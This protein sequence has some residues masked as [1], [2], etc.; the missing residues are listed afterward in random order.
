MLQTD[1][2]VIG[3]GATAMAFVDTLLAETTE[4][5]I[6]IV[7]R[8]PKPGGH[9]NFAY[10]FVTLHQ[11]STFYGVSS[12]ELSDGLINES[13]M[14]KGLHSL[15]N[16]D[17]IQ[18]YYHAVMEETFLPSG[19]IQ[20]FP[21]C[22]YKGEHKFESL[23]TGEKYE[24]EVRK[25]VVDT[26]YY[27]AAV[28]ATHTPNFEIAEGVQFM[29]I[30]GLVDVKEDPEGYVVVGGGKTGIDACLYLLENGTDPDKISWI[31]P[32]DAWLTNRQYTQPGM[33]FFEG[34]MGSQA[35]QMEAMATAKSI[36][37]MYEKL[38]AAEVVIRI[39]QDIF[40]KMFHGAT[41]SKPEVKA[42]RK[43]R[44]IIRL[45]R[46]QRIET[47]QIIF[48][49]GTLPTTPNHIHV[50]CSASALTNLVMKPIFEEKLIT[51]QTIRSYQPT[52]SASMIAY[53]EAN[54]KDVATKNK[55]CQVVQLPNHATDWVPMTETQ[56]LN[57]FTWS[58]DKKLRRWMRENRL[59]GFGKMITEMDRSDTKKM[60]IMGRIRKNSVPALLNLQAFGKRLNNQDTRMSN[61]QLQV[62]RDVFFKNRL[63]EMPKE[64]LEIQEG[65]I[66]VKIQKFAYT[67]NNITY[68]AAG[69]MIGYWNFFPPM[70]EET[71]GWGIIPVWGFAEVTESKHPE[72]PV[73]DKL[74]GYFPPAKYVKMKAVGVRE[75]R[76]IDGSAHR[77]KLP[78]VYNL[79]RRVLN[80]PNYN[81][82]YDRARMLLFPLH[83]TAYC[84]WD[85]VQMND[86]YGA[87]QIIILSASSKTSTGTA[88][89]FKADENSPKLI[90]M[91]SARNLEAVKGFNIYDEVLTY[92]DLQKIDPGTPT[93]IV[94]MSGN[95]K[96]M[97]GLHTLL[98][99]NMKFTI[100]VGLTHWDNTK[101]Q[102]GIIQGRSQFFFAPSHVQKRVSEIGQE[103]FDQL[104]AK[105]LMQTAAK[106]QEWLTFQTLKGLEELA[107]IHP[108]VCMGKIAPD[109][110]LIVEV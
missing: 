11:P 40:P 102:P 41:V 69:D 39:D 42:L 35:D 99:D 23:K 43:I 81:P 19:R 70:G 33:D 27:Q 29:P 59:D 44:D 51:P 15:A 67:A 45:G 3:C 66:L 17:Q 54:Y 65:E 79:Y 63:V 87:E 71:E 89:A 49:Q 64:E 93:V 95:A 85:S 36:E 38:E 8:N 26:T 34:T 14:N 82:V 47:D 92:D 32:R 103:G 57:Q 48:E 30:N 56:M 6:L 76:V 72:V 83:L 13:G 16:L 94:D 9:W 53:V 22:D 91:T 37:D 74:F 105:F 5:Q 75:G 58:K 10:P 84:I 18:S 31:M 97:A 90:G 80:E 100:N 86:W 107:D 1:Y 20:Y 77:A 52:F 78:K 61:P 21:E 46:V 108:D 55:I 24:V 98:G 68:A 50:D 7:D 88:Y 12:R 60:E 73:G 109:V 62:K 101:P 4:D 104:S 2:L 106:T 110:G 25:K 96:V 28:P